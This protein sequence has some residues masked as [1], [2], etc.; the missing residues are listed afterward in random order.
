MSNGTGMGLV[1]RV[2]V[3]TGAG[4]GLGRAACLSLAEAGASVVGLSIK[5]DELDELAATSE[6]RGLSI[7]CVRA[8]VG[9][10]SHVDEAMR[11]VVDRFGRVDLLIN[12]AAII[13]VCPIDD[14][15]IEE[16]D[17][18]MATN[19][20]S[21]FL[22]C[23]VT[24]PVMK[25]GGRGLIVNVSSR[26]GVEG[27]VGESA[28]CPSK[29]GLEG[30]TKTLALELAPAGITVVSV[31]P[32]APMRTPMSMST[33]PEELRAVWRD[34][35]ELAKGFVVLATES[36]AEDTGGRFDLWRLAQGHS[37]SES[38]GLR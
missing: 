16:W 36:G 17:R 37:V 26:S 27:F 6:A 7:D 5:V 19:L 10:E 28:Y 32:G 2:A 34:P 29:F 24:V 38:R 8:D 9:N 22:M 3:V 21:T 30:L 13:V 35:M 11:R 18:V 4:A 23:R 25:Q 33:Y 1:G 14:T 15:P 31:T 20:R 12:N